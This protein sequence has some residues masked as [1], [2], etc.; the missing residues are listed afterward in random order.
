MNPQIFKQAL[1]GALEE[2]G[3]I[4]ILLGGNGS[5]VIDDTAE[6]AG[7]SAYSIIPMSETVIAECIVYNE[8]T[9]TEQDYVS[10]KNWGAT[11]S[12]GS[13]HRV[14]MNCHIKSITL[15]SGS[16]VYY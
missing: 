2:T 16:I 7:L 14:P 13:L 10:V 8:S 1:I 6:H 5:N 4:R 9:G 3:L 15:T 12:A 11:L